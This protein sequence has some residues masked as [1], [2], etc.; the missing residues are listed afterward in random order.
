MGLG[1]VT[2]T[3]LLA[4]EINLVVVWQKDIDNVNGIGGQPKTRR[5]C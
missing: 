5:R 2:W 4:H 3:K 1:V